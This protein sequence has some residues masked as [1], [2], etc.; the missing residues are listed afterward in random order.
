[1]KSTSVNVR[2]LPVSAWVRGGPKLREEV[3][4]AQGRAV[5]FSLWGLGIKAGFLE[6]DVRH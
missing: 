1:M 5:K 6:V 4:P 3:G 2:P